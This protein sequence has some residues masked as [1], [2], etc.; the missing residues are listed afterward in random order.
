MGTFSACLPLN[1]VP[2]YVS[3]SLPV[4]HWVLK[5]KI[6]NKIRR[7]E[8]FVMRYLMIPTLVKRKLTHNPYLTLT[9]H[10]Y[11]QQEEEV[12]SRIKASADN[13]LALEE[14]GYA[15]FDLYP[16]RR[17]NLFSDEVYRLTKANDAST[18][19]SRRDVE[20]SDHKSGLPLNHKFSSNDVI[21]LTAQPRGSGDFF[22][23]SSL[24]TSSF[25]VSV[26]A[27]VLNA[28]PTYID[29]ALPGGAFEATFG[30]APNNAGDKKGDPRMRLRADLFFSTVPY[31]RMVQALGQI[32]SIPDRN[33]KPDA[34]GVAGKS[35]AASAHENICMD[36]VIRDAILST[37]VFDDVSSSN[38]RDTDAC[39]LREM[40]RHKK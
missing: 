7:A 34:K 40:V 12:L 39:D 27:R 21:V 14:A 23:P 5:N 26:E 37:Y 8:S 33:K 31:T 19:Y 36:E 9:S 28:G 18:T 38:F 10:S 35:S 20:D 15:L 32:T 1:I 16:E 4:G 24:P 3:S 13:P 22:G 11:T 25:A 17:G 29:I 2:R 30:P 6:S